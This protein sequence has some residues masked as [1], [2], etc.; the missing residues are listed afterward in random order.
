MVPQPCNKHLINGVIYPPLIIV[1]DTHS[2]AT[3]A[4]RDID[5]WV[6][7]G[8]QQ[9]NKQIADLRMILREICLRVWLLVHRAGWK[10]IDQITKFGGELH[11]P[12]NA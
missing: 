5:M 1:S 11:F 2:V 8:S 9:T 4:L 7:K 3:T 10:Q 6:W 12:G